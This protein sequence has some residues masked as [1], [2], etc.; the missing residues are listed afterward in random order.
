[1]K[2]LKMAGLAAVAGLLMIAAPGNRAEAATVHSP[3]I[4]ASVQAGT[5]DA[6]TEVQ[7]RHGHHARHH[8]Y[9]HR[10]HA[11]RRWVYPHRHHRHHHR[12][13]R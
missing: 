6:V 9:M 8:R 4:A 10:H 13:W 5:L 11:H 2:I 1:M 3:G 7:Y 12:H